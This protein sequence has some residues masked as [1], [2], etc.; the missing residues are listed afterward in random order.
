MSRTWKTLLAISLAVCLLAP[1]A[2]SGPVGKIILAESQFEKF[3]SLYLP[4]SFV[5]EQLYVLCQFG[6]DPNNRMAC[7]NGVV[8]DLISVTNVAVPG[9]PP[10]GRV[11]MLSDTE[12]TQGLV[13]PPDFPLPGPGAPPPIFLAE[14]GMAQTLTP[15]GG[16]KTVNPDGSPG[17]N[18]K[19]MATSDPDTQPPRLMSDVLLVSTL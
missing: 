13:V 12:G 8:S 6:V 9:T 5:S 15:K 14:T 16:L 10:E 3:G 11:S 19:I 2:Y 18:I 7:V 1:N 4:F 17:P